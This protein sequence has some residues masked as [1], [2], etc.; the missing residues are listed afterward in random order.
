MPQAITE[1]F[2]HQG[3]R[4]MPFNILNHSFRHQLN[5]GSDKCY[6]ITTTVL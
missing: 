6:D 2:S 4:E 5:L 3:W 1:A